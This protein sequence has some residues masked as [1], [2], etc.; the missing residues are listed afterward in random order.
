VQLFLIYALSS[1]VLSI[2]SGFSSLLFICTLHFLIAIY[3][4]HSP[5]GL[6]RGR[7]PLTK[8]LQ[9][10]QHQAGAWHIAG[11]KHF[12]S[13]NWGIEKCLEKLK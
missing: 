8:S 1:V 2:L 4:P 11:T 6:G 7:L 10:P 12:K 3:I 5:V 9:N 13:V